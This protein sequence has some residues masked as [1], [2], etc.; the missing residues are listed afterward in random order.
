MLEVNFIKN[1]REEVLERFKLLKILQILLIDLILG[2]DNERKSLQFEHDEMQANINVAS[3]EIGEI[4]GKIKIKSLLK[5]NEV[6]KFKSL[7]Q[8]LKARLGNS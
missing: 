8:P 3:R 4:D 6:A 2:L 5:K 7:L 1:N